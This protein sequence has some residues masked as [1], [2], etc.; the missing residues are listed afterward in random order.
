MTGREIILIGRPAS[1]VTGAS[2]RLLDGFIVEL[3]KL[4]TET[5]RAIA[6]ERDEIDPDGWMQRCIRGYLDVWR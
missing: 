5:L 4:D 3:S 6:A 2:E 1:P